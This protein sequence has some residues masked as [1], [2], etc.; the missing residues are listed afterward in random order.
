MSPWRSGIIAW[1]PH[2][3]PLAM[4]DRPGPLGERP[5]NLTEFLAPCLV[6][7][8]SKDSVAG[9]M[10]WGVSQRHSLLPGTPHPTSKDAQPL[11]SDWAQRQVH[12]LECFSLLLS[13][14]GPE[15]LTVLWS[16]G[17]SALESH[18]LYL[19]YVCDIPK[20]PHFLTVSQSR[21]VAWDVSG[22][23]PNSLLWGQGRGASH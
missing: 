22:K 3:A 23:W 11:P 17:S 18:R 1:G 19:V 15:P 7:R 20:A 2:P 14:Q 10:P 5:S 4:P 9:S 21:P 8:D 13:G 16:T 12:L 6:C